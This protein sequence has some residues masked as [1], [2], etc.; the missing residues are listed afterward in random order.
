MKV[1]V[2]YPHPPEPDGVSM[3]GHY[4]A[5][6]LE[7][8]GVEVLRCD[9][10]N[11]LQKE[12]SYLSF[13]PDFVVGVGFWG[14][15]PGLVKDPMS[16]GMKPVPW[17]NADAWVANYHKGL[18]E[19]PLLVVTSNWVKETYIRD[20]LSGNNIHV[21]PIGFNPESFHPIE[22]NDSKVRQLREL[23]DIKDDEKM[24]LTIG[25][26][27]TSKGAQE[28]LRA[29]GEVNKKFPKW[30]YVMK[31]WESFSARNHQEEEM[32]LIKELGLEE[33]I[34][35]LV[36]KYSPEFMGIL[37]NACDVYAAPSRIEG[38]GMIQLEAMACGKPVVS[39]N[40][41]GPR[42]TIIDGKTGFLV[43]VAHEVK[44]NKEWV[45]PSMGF[46]EEKQIEFPFPKTFAYRAN[47]EQLGDR[48]LMLL[49][50]D[51][52]RDEIGKN[53]AQHALE[54]FHYKKTAKRMIELIEKYAK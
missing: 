43:D 31:F 2:L 24:I 23:L 52:L 44:L 46:S 38:F 45:Y 50:D 15:F 26:D 13:K 3:Q 51:S 11:N 9:R 40:V 19:L 5:K 42:D 41:G 25:G 30:K 14:D 1:L 54:N 7:E 22:K 37:L 35:Y 48:I 16:Y 47:I 20:G 49:K 4:L 39:I 29:L 10:E 34:I 12:W 8:N 18:E 21:C 28:I 36:G 33:K 27:V 6:G 17:F 32:K 53:A